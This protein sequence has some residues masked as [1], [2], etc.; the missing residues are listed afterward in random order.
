MANDFYVYVHSRPDGSIFYVGKGHGRRAWDFSPSRRSAHHMSIVRKYGRESIRVAVLPQVS[1]E[2]AFAFE[3]DMIALLRAAGTKLINRTEGGEGAAGR[4]QTDAQRA[5]FALGRGS[6]E[7]RGITPE[8]R[9]RINAALRASKGKVAAW[10]Q[11]P[12]GQAHI[13][14]LGQ[15][16]AAATAARPARTVCCEHCSFS[17][18][19]KSH[20]ARFCSAF[21]GQR[22]RREKQCL[23]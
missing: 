13:K 16:S 12:E 11:S 2:A 4:P 5:G 9:A 17:F 21:C 8:S 1:E 15:L 19:T 6:D 14:R 10:K 20:T 3:R 23:S 22:A 7:S 18:E